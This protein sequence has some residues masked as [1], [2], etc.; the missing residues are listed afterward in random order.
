MKRLQDDQKEKITKSPKDLLI[1]Q[2]TE[3]MDNMTEGQ[4]A[5]YLA[6]NFSEY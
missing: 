5:E 2:E 4:L 6:E 3:M 1:E